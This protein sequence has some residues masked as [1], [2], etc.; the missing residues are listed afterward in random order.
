MTVILAF[1]VAPVWGGGGWRDG[2]IRLGQSISAREWQQASHVDVLCVPWVKAANTVIGASKRGPK[3]E[4]M[5][6][7][8]KV[9]TW[10]RD[11]WIFV[12]CDWVPSGE[13]IARIEPLVGKKYDTRGALC[14]ILPDRLCRS[15]PN[16]DRWFCSGVAA[17]ALNYPAPH[18]FSPGELF[19]DLR[20]FGARIVEMEAHEGMGRTKA[21]VQ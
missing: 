2:A 3:G 9:I 16:E 8:R 11:H 21:V 12:A 5:K 20:R 4:R 6:V 15:E 14:S 1:Y 17:R 19:A 18:L 13:A 10:Q 7:R